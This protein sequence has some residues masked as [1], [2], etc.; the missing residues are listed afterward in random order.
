MPEAPEP[1][2]AASFDVRYGD[3]EDVSRTGPLGVS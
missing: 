3:R 1:R 2:Q